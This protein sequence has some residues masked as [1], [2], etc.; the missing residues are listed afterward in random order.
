MVTMEEFEVLEKI[1]ATLDKL[2]NSVE[3]VIT[4]IESFNERLEE[5]NLKQDEILEKLMNLSSSGD[6]YEVRDGF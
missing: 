4:E 2:I 3:V 5:I 1:T 6:G